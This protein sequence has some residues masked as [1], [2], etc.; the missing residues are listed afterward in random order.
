MTARHSPLFTLRSGQSGLR[1]YITQRGATR[2]SDRRHAPHHGDQQLAVKRNLVGDRG[3]RRVGARHQR[4]FFEAFGVARTRRTPIL[5]VTSNRPWGAATCLY[6]TT[7]ISPCD[8]LAKT[9]VGQ[10]SPKRV[11]ERGSR[12]DII[13]EPANSS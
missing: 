7:I 2:R 1:I 6:P 10:T 4:T 11:K 12:F 5:W 13:S 3:H 9:L 8:N